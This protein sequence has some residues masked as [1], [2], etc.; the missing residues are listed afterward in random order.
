MPAI[1]LTPKAL[2]A[3]NE[4]MAEDQLEISTRL[5]DESIDMLLTEQLPDSAE[6]T[7]DI[8]KAYRRLG[9]LFRTI[10]ENRKEEQ[11]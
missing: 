11:S 1:N 3:V 6:E 10:Q 5:M 8:V 4:L 2:E 9:K 7:I